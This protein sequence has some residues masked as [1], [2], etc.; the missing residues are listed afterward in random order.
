VFEAKQMDY[1]PKRGY[2]ATLGLLGLLGLGVAGYFWW[3]MQPK[4]GFV[5]ANAPPPT[6]AAQTAQQAAQT[7][8]AQPSAAAQ[9]PASAPAAPPPPPAA[10]VAPAPPAAASV[11][12]A[13]PS[14]G[15]PVAA[16]PPETSAVPGTRGT[17]R[18]PASAAKAEPPMPPQPMA[19]SAPRPRPAPPPSPEG[20]APAER[21]A[22]MAI[23]PTRTLDRELDNAYTAFEAG[24]YSAARRSYQQVLRADPTNRDAML[25]LAAIDL[26]AGDEGAAQARYQKLIERDPRDPYA[27]AAIV[28]LRPSADPVQSESRLKTLIG[29]QPDSAPLQF[30]LGNLYSGQSRWSEA[31]AAYFKAYSGDPDNADFAYNLAVSLDHLRQ[32]RLA[33]EYYQRALALAGERPV[34]FDR[35]RAAARARD[36]ER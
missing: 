30:A 7:A 34:S 20:A 29:Q 26:R 31:Q 4:S 32:P 2:Y 5:V 33:L 35:A 22:P 28:G 24:D 14:T 27:H 9:P 17:T 1:N 10:A 23:V 11:V 36:L 21:R 13:P 19:A 16:A 15:A 25:G 3:E 12:A 6:P 8:A 18:T